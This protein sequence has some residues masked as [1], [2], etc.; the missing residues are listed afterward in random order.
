MK[1]NPSDAFQRLRPTCVKLSKEPTLSGVQELRNAFDQVEPNNLA[2]LTEYLLF[3]L[4][5]TLQRNGISNE[6]KQDVVD[7]IKILLQKVKVDKPN[8]FDDLFNLL[9]LSLS[10]KE[11]GK[12]ADIAEELRLSIINCLNCLI[13]NSGLVTRSVIYRERYLPSVGHAVSLLLSVAE[14]DKAR[15]IQV[16]ALSCLRKI[17]FCDSQS[18]SDLENGDA[19]QRDAFG[20]RHQAE[21]HEMLASICDSAASTMASFLPGISMALVRIICGDPNQGH[22]ILSSS[23]D[24][25]GDLVSMVMSDKYVD[26]LDSRE[27]DILSTLSGLAKLQTGSALQETQEEAEINEQKQ[28]TKALKVNP[29][30]EWFNTTAAKL[31][32]L[33]EK[34]TSASIS[35]SNW[36]VRLSVVKLCEKILTNCT[37]SM[38]KSASLL[39][40]ILVG[41]LEDEYPQVSME[42]KAVLEHMSKNQMKDGNVTVVWLPIFK[43]IKLRT[44]IQSHGFI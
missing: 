41:F 7:C 11:A 26:E 36:R 32:V 15:H 29:D 30:K 12:V 1:D 23:I 14:H 38:A 3:P 6:L 17:S 4:Q 34:L 43:Q 13:D 39:V 9:T 19:E 40:D 31:Q 42:S 8:I 24:M 28:P 44:R 27:D 33:I 10:A 21:E 16:A 25:F 22:V 20:A 18:L 5:L 2:K 37:R 35:S